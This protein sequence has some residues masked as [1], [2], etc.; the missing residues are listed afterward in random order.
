ML[1]V[2]LGTPSS[3][4]ALAKGTAVFSADERELGTVDEV[5]A[6]ADLDIFDGIVIAGG[7]AGR[8]FVSADHVREIFDRGVLLTLS[9]ADAGSLPEHG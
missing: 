5:R 2:D 7:S 6:A 8:R 3:Y 9:A 4:L 1:A